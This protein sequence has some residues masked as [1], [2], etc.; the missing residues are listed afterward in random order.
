MVTLLVKG[1][2]GSILISWTQTCMLPSSVGGVL[3]VTS[4]HSIDDAFCITCI[5]QEEH[6]YR[7]PFLL[8]V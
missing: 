3:R 7:V 1:E 5:A 4:R 2:Q 8:T 6:L